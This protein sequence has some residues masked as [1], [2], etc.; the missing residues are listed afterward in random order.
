[1]RRF[2]ARRN[3]FALAVVAG[4]LLFGGGEVSAAPPTSRL[5]PPTSELLMEPVIEPGW[6]DEE[7]TPWVDAG[8][9][10]RWLTYIAVFLMLGAVAFGPIATRAFR[11]AQSSL[12]PLRG[13]CRSMAIRL[14]LT[15]SLLF[16]FG[17]VGR[18][19][20][21]VLAF[22][23][24]GDPVV[25]ADVR[26]M[27]VDTSWGHG[28]QIQVACAIVAGVGFVLARRST[29]WGMPLAWL[30]AL[31]T[32]VTLPLTGHAVAASWSPLLT[33][34]LQAL[35]VLGGGVWLG[36]LLVVTIVAFS[37]TSGAEESDRE[38]II[39]E[40]VHA[41]SPM[42]LGGVA[43]AV[44]MGLVL[45]VSYIGSWAGLWLTSYGRV[46]L[47]KI[48]LLG[49]VGLIGA[50]NWRRVRPRLGT[51]GSAGVLRLSARVELLVGAVLLAATAILV[52][53]PAPHV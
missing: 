30:G 45:S 5:A 24:P 47:V 41:F 39:A 20:G 16:L 37:A 29:K 43:V 35:H 33:V 4:A 19:Y 52:A 38:R 18:L 34:P 51:P 28:W 10:G 1:M 3:R 17:A 46:L 27:I 14:G 6:Q 36:S 7:A 48:A 44:A 22:V 8:T 15:G 23:F 31:A 2:A 11:Q 40:L 25:M 9:A 50:Y 53:L 21:Q 32:A 42:A 12:D 49:I 26:L 13:R